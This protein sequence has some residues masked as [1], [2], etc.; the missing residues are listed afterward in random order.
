VG[1]GYV[2][3]F[4]GLGVDFAVVAPRGFRHDPDFPLP[5]GVRELT[6]AEARGASPPPVGLGFLH[7]PHVNRL[8][9]EVKAN[10]LVWESDVVPR[11]WVQA[12]ARH[13]D[14][15]VVPSEFTRDALIRSGLQGDRV[16]VVPYGHAVGE[17]FELSDVASTGASRAAR[18][19]TF[20]S[21]AAPHERK[22]I[23][24][25][26]RAYRRAF[27][28]NDDVL[29]RIKTTYDPAESKRRFPFEISGWRS[30]L[31]DCGL[32]EAGSPRVIV[33]RRTLRDDELLDVY[34]EAHVYVQPTW[35]ESF[36]LALLDAM[37]LGLP[38][39]A[40]GWGGHR[41][42]FP[43]SPDAIPYRIEEAGSRLYQLTPG[44]HVAIPDEEALATRM[45][46]HREHPE[47]SRTLGLLSRQHVAC[48]TWRRSARRLL[49]VLG[50]EDG[51]AACE[52]RLVEDS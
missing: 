52:R 10:L 5:E 41:G 39:I 19:F 26:L 21:I 44:A 22:G 1:R 27:P 34:Q 37:A 31:E 24:Q 47:D 35:G 33:D 2:R 40:T 13:V 23:R 12:L 7:P 28:M 18:P 38:A 9:G 4:L 43:E 16:S 15:V 17:C 6:V 42:Y 51:R 45:R 14:R 32:A 3:E 48:W 30:V 46:W 20:L 50:L 11:G 36:G 8:V 49:Q 29:L 25:L